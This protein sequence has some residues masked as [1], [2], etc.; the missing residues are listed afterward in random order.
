MLSM[1]YDPKSRSV[2]APGGTSFTID[3][4]TA[5]Q[6]LGLSFA[7]NKV[8]SKSSRFA[9][10]V[11]S[12]DTNLMNQGSKIDDLL[13]MVTPD[14]VVD[15]FSRVFFLIVLDFF[16]AL[17]VIQESDTITMKLSTM[18]LQSRNMTGVVKW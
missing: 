13:R 12:K 5:H 7:G 17:P 6:I 11:I 14:M 1:H 16:S 2:K 18:H 4:C 15:R 3:A 8:P 9:K 10:D